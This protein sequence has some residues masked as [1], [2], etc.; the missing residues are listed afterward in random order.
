MPSI[1]VE[2]SRPRAGTQRPSRR[3]A[4]GATGSAGRGRAPRSGNPRR[5]R[6]RW[7]GRPR[8]CSGQGRDARIAG[9]GGPDGPDTDSR[10]LSAGG[11]HA[12]VRGQGTPV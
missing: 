7:L 5:F 1:S 9:G 10:S 8:L 4:G 3:R 11:R 6:R 2:P 12:G